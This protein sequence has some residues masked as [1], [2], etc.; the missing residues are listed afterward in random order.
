MF[1]LRY[2]FLKE[3]KQK[4]EEE[5]ARQR[6]AEEEEA[7]RQAQEAAEVARKAQEA[8][9]AARQEREA[10]EAARRAQEEAKRQ[11]DAEEAT[12][13]V[14]EAEE[15]ATKLFKEKTKKGASELQLHNK[16]EVEMNK[17]NDSINLLPNSKEKESQL[18]EASSQYEADLQHSQGAHKHNRSLD[19]LEK[20]NEDIEAITGPALPKTSVS[21]EENIKFPQIGSPTTNT[22]HPEP[23]RS[24]APQ[25]VK[26]PASRSQ[27]KREQR[28]QRGLEHSQRESVRAAAAGKDESCKELTDSTF[29]S[30]KSGKL[31]KENED[32]EKVNKVKEICPVRP[33]SLS[34]DVPASNEPSKHTSVI[35]DMPSRGKS[36]TQP[37]ITLKEPRHQEK[38][39]TRMLK[40]GLF[41]KGTVQPKV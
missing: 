39:R 11:K 34:L 21:A 37:E 28:R 17:Q 8:E 4:R 32:E 40:Y 2:K 13:S 6:K 27:E 35:K 24:R 22:T 38:E 7:A 19:A 26:L 41:L 23:G 10:A 14:K 15:E 9:E 25:I 29:I 33:S 5:E 18:T 3:E 16:S 30:Q 31:K 36:N 1:S 20:H 12:R